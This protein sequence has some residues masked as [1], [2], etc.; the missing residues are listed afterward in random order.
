[1]NMTE[2]GQVIL[3]KESHLYNL[4]VAALASLSQVQARSLS[5]EHAI[6]ILAK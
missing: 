5:V 3:G 4:V 6:T 2:R 1:M